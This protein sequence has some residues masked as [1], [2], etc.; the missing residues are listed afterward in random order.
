MTLADVYV[1][2]RDDAIQIEIHDNR[3]RQ[4]VHL[5]TWRRG[6]L[7]NRDGSGFAAIIVLPV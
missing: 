1:P 6:R 5:R 7:R 3:H 2:I 4:I